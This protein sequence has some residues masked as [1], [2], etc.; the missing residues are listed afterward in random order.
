MDMELLDLLE[1]RITTLVTE[2]NQLRSVHKDTLAELETVRIAR[3]ALEEENRALKE[4][5][6]QEEAVKEDI[7]QRIDTMLSKLDS[8]DAPQ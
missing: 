5:L 7:S 6:T 8:V 3:S 1:D 2:L 4:T